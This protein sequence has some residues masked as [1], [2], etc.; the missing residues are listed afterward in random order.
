M[1]RPAMPVPCRRA[2]LD[3]VLGGHPA[4]ERRRLRADALLE[5]VV[6][7]A[8]ARTRLRRG[9]GCWGGGRRRRRSLRRR[10]R[11]LAPR[12][13]AAAGRR[14]G[15]G[16]RRSPRSRPSRARDDRLHRH[17]LPFG[18]QDL[19]EHAARRRR[20]LR[21]DLVRRDLEDRLVALHLRRRPSSAT[22]TACLRRSTRPSGA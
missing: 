12:P 22:S 18:H 5:R 9:G 21:V 7:V 15:A 19:G 6:A 1:T 8:R 16:A 13:P 14:G 20:N 3:A 2:D 17:R 10:P 4:D 11:R